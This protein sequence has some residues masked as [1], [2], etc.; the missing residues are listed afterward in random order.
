VRLSPNHPLWAERS[1]NL[2]AGVVETLH[3]S[4]SARGF[5]AIKQRTCLVPSG[6]WPESL[7]TQRVIGSL[8]RLLFT[9]TCQG[10]AALLLMA[11]M[12]EVEVQAIITGILEEVT[13]NRVKVYMKCH[14]WSARKM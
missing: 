14:R 10:L 4:P 9:H 12:E 8:A 3:T 2:D 6:P 7:E 11:G 1:I 13:D 5:H